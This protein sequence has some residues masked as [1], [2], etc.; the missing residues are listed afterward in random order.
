MPDNR[1]EELRLPPQASSA[2]LHVRDQMRALSHGMRSTSLVSVPLVTGI[3]MIVAGGTDQERAAVTEALAS[4]LHRDVFRLDL[5]ALISQF[6]GETEK[7]IDRVFAM[8]EKAGAVL[9]FDE[10]D[11]L[12]GKRSE[13]KD[14]HDRYANLEVTYLLSRIESYQGL[15]ILATNTVDDID[16]AFRRRF[17]YVVRLEGQA[18]QREDEKTRRREDETN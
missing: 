13:V 6:V 2:L 18:E 16:P 1:V 11:A 15:A 12:F 17:R 5:A 14:A 3:P 10:A 9:V 8:A 4:D 7:N